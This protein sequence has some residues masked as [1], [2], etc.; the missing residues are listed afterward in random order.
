MAD[1]AQETYAIG[2]Y[3]DRIVSGPIFRTLLWLG[4]PLLLSHLIFVVYHVTDAYWLSLY[5][6]VTVAVP[7]QV[8]PVVMLFQALLNALTA[9]CMSIVSQQIGSKNYREASLSAS[10]FFTAAILTGASQCALLLMLREYIFTWVISTPKEIFEDMM[11]YSAVMSFDVFFNCI[12]FTYLTLIQSVGDT[13]RSALLNS[14]AVGI[15]VLLDP[16]LVLGIGFFP[17][18]G[19]IGASMTDVLGKIISI[20]GLNYIIRKNYPELKVG[21]TRNI[22]LEWVRLVLRIGLPVVA[23]GLTNGLAF[24]VQLK[25]V[26][27]LGIVAATAYSIGFVIMDIVDGALWGLSGAN[28]IMVGQSLGAGNNNRAREISYKSALLLFAIVAAGSALVYPARTILVDAFADDPN[29]LAEAE[30]FLR[31][32]LPTLPFFGIFMISM[33]TGRGSGHTTFP[34]II[35]ILRLW[36]VRVALGYLL[37]FYLGMGTLG[38]WLAISLGNVVGGVAAILWIKYGGWAEAVIKKS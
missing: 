32:L 10:R 29:I 19:V 35:G 18:L 15:N 37:A 24:L 1:E 2:K 17:R 34:T 27:M 13:K 3:R 25:I 5:G 4:A 38:A 28:S 21:F 12:S 26:N 11:K 33:S 8:W 30:L 36:V 16:F 23:L 9:A 22:D 20:V 14:I 31:N 6:E 7:R